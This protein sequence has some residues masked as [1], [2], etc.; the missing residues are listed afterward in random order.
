[1]NGKDGE[2][3]NADRRPARRHLPPSVGVPGGVS[4]G[5]W[6]FRGDASSGQSGGCEGRGVLLAGLFVS[7]ILRDTRETKAD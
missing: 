6:D 4:G 1:M 7:I 5:V 2:G 3:K